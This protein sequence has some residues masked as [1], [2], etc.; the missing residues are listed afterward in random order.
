M[1]ERQLNWRRNW[2]GV[3]ALITG[4]LLFWVALHSDGGDWYISQTHGDI[5]YTALSR[6][7]EW[8]YFSWVFN[9]GTYFLQDP[10]S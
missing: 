3:A 6:F 5:M 7:R 8:P 4:A 10:Q 2:I 9:G 1:V